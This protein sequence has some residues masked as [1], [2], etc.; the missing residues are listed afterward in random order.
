MVCWCTLRRWGPEASV[1]HLRRAIRAYNEATGT[2]NTST[3][4]Y[5]E[6]LTRYYVQA[7]HAAAASRV[8]ELF[9]APGCSRRAPLDF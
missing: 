1:H 4:G 7:V 6:T 9:M 3:S 5:H 8:S 2:P